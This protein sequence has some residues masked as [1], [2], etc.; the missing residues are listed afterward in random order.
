MTSAGWLLPWLLLWVLAPDAVAEPDVDVS[1]DGSRLEFRLDATMRAPPSQVETVL[2]DYS[3]FD[4]VLPLVVESRSLGEVADGV[5]RVA[6]RMRGCVL[7]LC[8]EID[9]VFDVRAIPGQWSSGITVPEL[10]R[11]RRGHMSWR[12]EAQDG[13]G[14]RSRLQLYGYFEPDFS[15]PRLLGPPLVRLWVGSELEKSVGRIEEAALALGERG[16]MAVE[17]R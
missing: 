7:F 1:F 17:A 16:A 5:E 15:V 4:R 2:N 6:T 8:R 3:R 13:D 11:I 9:H 12:I 10:S 14:A